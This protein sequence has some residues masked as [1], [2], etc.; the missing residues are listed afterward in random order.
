MGFNFRLRKCINF[1]KFSQ[2]GDTEIIPSLSNRLLKIDVAPN[3]P[4]GK[5]LVGKISPIFQGLPDSISY[6][7]YSGSEIFLL[8]E[9]GTYSLRFT[10]SGA[11]RFGAVRFFEKIG[12][13]SDSELH[14]FQ[15][16]LGKEAE[17]ASSDTRNLINAVQTSTASIASNQ[18]AQDSINSAN[19]AA[20]TAAQL[21]ADNFNKEMIISEKFSLSAADFVAQL[22]G[23]YHAIVNLILVD[24]SKGVSLT[25]T[26][27]D[28]DDQ[29]FS[30]LISPYMG[31]AQKACAEISASQLADNSYPL[32]LLCQGHKLISA[33]AVPPA[34]LSLGNGFTAEKNADILHIKG[35]TGNAIATIASVAEA[36][37]FSGKVYI[38]FNAGNFAFME[39]PDFIMQ[40]SNSA[41]FTASQ[42]TGVLI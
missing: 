11:L 34:G 27:A 16:L 30:Q 41:D 13:L 23:V 19:A 24:G 7:I 14:Q 22:N 39:P 21:A 10:S 26:D 38:S 37:F 17:M 15:I 36:R 33:P 25:L 1:S 29:G 12:H 31:D 20:I 5:I 4:R 42:A 3:H 40:T 2:A 28:G 35:P 8:P 18:A 32:S 6:K 9:L